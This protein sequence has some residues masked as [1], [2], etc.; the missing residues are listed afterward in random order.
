[1]GFHLIVKPMHEIWKKTVMDVWLTQ[2]IKKTFMVYALVEHLSL[3]LS[4]A[5][6]VDDCI[7]LT[8]VYSSETSWIICRFL[9]SP[10][11]TMATLTQ[12][13]VADAG[14]WSEHGL[15]F[16]PAA[17]Q[18]QDPSQTLDLVTRNNLTQFRGKMLFGSEKSVQRSHD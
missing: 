5:N 15:V 18:C 13:L 9:T 10:S 12:T 4:L 7:R 17:C 11:R 16:M 6:T 14:Y 2:P 3:E 1:M 8:D